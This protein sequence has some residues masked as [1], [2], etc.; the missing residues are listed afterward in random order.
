MWARAAVI[1]E[2]DTGPQDPLLRWLIHGVGKLML[3]VGR[4]PCISL[5]PGPLR[6]AAWG[7]LWCDSWLLAEGVIWVLEVTHCPLCSVSPRSAGLA[8]EGDSAPVWIP[9]GR[10]VAAGI[11]RAGCHIPAVVF[12]AVI[13]GYVWSVSFCSLNVYVL[14]YRLVSVNFG[15]C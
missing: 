12:M 2:L 11:L 10:R 13:L 8:V 7:S 15:V 9:G 3:G 6:R 1:W 5:P 4:M 14:S